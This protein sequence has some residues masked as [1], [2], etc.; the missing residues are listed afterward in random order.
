[1][2][3]FVLLVGLA[4][5]GA[6]FWWVRRRRVVEEEVYYLH[7]CRKCRQKVRYPASHAGR[8][9]LCP[10]CNWPLPLPAAGPKVTATSAPRRRVRV[11]RMAAVNRLERSA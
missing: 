10:R 4:L 2:T 5:G 11:A 8:V 6:A 1:V 7:C 9:E 3:T